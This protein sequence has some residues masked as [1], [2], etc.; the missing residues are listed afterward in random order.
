MTQLEQESESKKDLNIRTA[1]LVQ[2]LSDLGP[3][4]P[5]IARRLGQ[6]KESVR[7]RYK[8]KILNSGFAVQAM[9]DHEKLGLRRVFM[10]A[11][12]GEEYRA[13]AQP[14]MIAMNELCYVVGY[15][16]TIPDGRFIIS[17]SVPV[18]YIASFQNFMYKLR[19][20]GLFSHLEIFSFDWFKNV[21]MKAE[22]YD[23]NTGR[24]DFGWSAPSGNEFQVASYTPAQTGKFDYLDLLLLKELMMDANKPLT[25]IAEKLNVNYKKLAWHYATHVAR[26]R[27]IKFYRINWMGTRYDYKIEKALHRKHRY[28]FVD[29]LVMN[30]DHVSRM[31]LMSKMAG[32]PFLWAEASGIHYFAE[33]AFPVDFV[34][35]GL[36]YLEEVIS[37]VRDQ[38]KYF[39]MDQTNALA[40]TIAYKLYDQTQKKWV[41]NEQELT[42][43]FDN[44]IM[45]IKGGLD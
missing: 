4:I 32:L 16:K 2:L 25:E 42:L 37:P 43:R 7:Y 27:L 18:E 38:S 39:I 12:F 22:H 5:E 8:E 41:F 14:I 40:F 30:L 45:K 10:I 1:Q 34:T 20:R 13:Y 36:Q 21:P 24:W 35:E 33:I 23:F 11:D 3:D 19:D 17:A 9:P 28:V 29:L 44:L 26:E 6:Y 31:R 15:T